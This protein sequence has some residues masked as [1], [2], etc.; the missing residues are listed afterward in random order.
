MKQRHALCAPKWNGIII[1]IKY[2]FA[3]PG[4]ANTAWSRKSIF[5][6]RHPSGVGG[7]SGN[8]IWGDDQCRH[9]LGCPL[10]NYPN[11]YSVLKFY[12]LVCRIVTKVSLWSL[13]LDHLI[14]PSSRLLMEWKCR[15][16]TLELYVFRIERQ[17]FEFFQILEQ[18]FLQCINRKVLCWLFVAWFFV[19]LT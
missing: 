10:P 1:S 5:G 13:D 11:F 2:G 12:S 19:C 15:Q 16:P 9:N 8:Q 14:A 4:V 7:W 18:V 17:R 3:P 6:S